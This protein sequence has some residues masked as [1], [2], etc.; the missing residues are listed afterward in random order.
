MFSQIF[1]S[2]ASVGREICHHLPVHG[3]HTCARDVTHEMMVGVDD[4]QLHGIRP[5]KDAHHLLHRVV[6][7][8]CCWWLR[9]ELCHGEVVIEFGT[10]D[11]MPD[12]GEVDLTEQCACLVEHRQY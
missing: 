4:R 11:Y 5:F 1:L 6:D 8:K 10:E 12:F 9:H 3:I 2:R 7:K